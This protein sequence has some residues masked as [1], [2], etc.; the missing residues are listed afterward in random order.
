MSNVKLLSNASPQPALQLQTE[1]VQGWQGPGWAKVGSS[2]TLGGRQR[3]PSLT[4]SIVIVSRGYTEISNIS[5]QSY[6]LSYSKRYVLRSK[7][8]PTG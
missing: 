1:P 7:L 2:G 4:S 5:S 8:M 3:R 6:V